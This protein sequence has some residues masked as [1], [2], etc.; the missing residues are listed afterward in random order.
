[1]ESSSSTEAKSPGI[2]FTEEQ[3]EELKGRIL[4]ELETLESIYVDEGVVHQPPKVTQI[5]KSKPISE[6]QLQEKAEL[7][8][9]KILEAAERQHVSS[10]ATIRMQKKQPK[11]K[12][13]PQGK[14]V[15]KGELKK[16][17]SK[18]EQT[19]LS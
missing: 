19:R 5:V 4:E 3:C 15:K 1:M 9:A 7:M 13:Q 12:K 14:W 18:S 16:E 10:A 8:N 2:I 17:E 6:E 11:G